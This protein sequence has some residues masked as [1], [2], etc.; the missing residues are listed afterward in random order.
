MAIRKFIK[1]A[2][3]GLLDNSEAVVPKPGYDSLDGRTTEKETS[4]MYYT[5]YRMYLTNI[6]GYPINLADKEE[7]LDLSRQQ[8]VIEM[9][10]FPPRTARSRSGS[11]S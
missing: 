4:I 8:A 6:M 7:A 9:P 11:G 1:I 2:F 10:A 5:N 3:I